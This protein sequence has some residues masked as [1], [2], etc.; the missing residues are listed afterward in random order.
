MLDMNL[1]ATMLMAV[2]LVGGAALA[3]WQLPWSEAE[4]READGDAR[5]L[6][7]RVAAAPR[8]RAAEVVVLR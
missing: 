5:R 4:L 8:A 6:A 3:I 7:A 2:G 1:M